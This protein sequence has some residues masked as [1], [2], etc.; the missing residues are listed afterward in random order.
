MFRTL[1]QSL[2]YAL[3]AAGVGYFAAAPAYQAAAPSAAQIKLSFSRAGEHTAECRRL[4]PEEIALLPPNMRRPLDC[5]RSRVAV[6]VQLLLDGAVIYEESVPPAGLAEDGNSVFYEKFT[7]T[8][9]EHTLQVR[10]NDTRAPEGYV[11]DTEHRFDLAPGEILVID[12][13]STGNRF[14]FL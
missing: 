9:G 8:P 12:F 4:T 13:D 2:V 1:A 5:P 7:V 11:V 10:M 14:L 6:R 3:L